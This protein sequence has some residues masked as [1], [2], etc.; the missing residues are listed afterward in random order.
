MRNDT[1]NHVF[2]EE[3]YAEL[4]P[5]NTSSDLLNTLRRQYF[6]PKSLNHL[7]PLIGKDPIEYGTEITNWDVKE[8]INTLR[9]SHSYFHW[10][11]NKASIKEISASKINANQIDI[12]KKCLDFL[13]SDENFR[14]RWD[15]NEKLAGIYDFDY[16]FNSASEYIHNIESDKDRLIDDYYLYPICKIILLV[17]RYLEDS[18]DSKKPPKEAEAQLPWPPAT[19]KQNTWG[20]EKIPPYKPGTGTGGKIELY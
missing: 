3:M 19:P 12:V 14:L 4:N 20:R 5:G 2:N 11:L 15:I 13:K 17:F 7:L 6:Q 9:D 1:N 8:I 18:I 16:Y 10:K